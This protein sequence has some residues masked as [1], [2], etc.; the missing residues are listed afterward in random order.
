MI[1]RD[2][3]GKIV[4]FEIRGVFCFYVWNMY[5]MVYVY[6]IYIGICDNENFDLRNYL[7]FLYGSKNF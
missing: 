4:I 6:C 1:L 3:V 2:V 5:V 7:M